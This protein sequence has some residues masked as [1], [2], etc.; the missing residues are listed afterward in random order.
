MEDKERSAEDVVAEMMNQPVAPAPA[1]DNTQTTAQSVETQTVET[2][3][4][5][6]Q[7]VAEA[8]TVAPVVESQPA[9]QEPQEPQVAQTTEAQPVEAQPTETQPVE[10][11]SETQ[12]VAAPTTPMPEPM[13]QPVS[14]PVM[15]EAAPEAAPQTESQP[16]AMPQSE[17]MAT[18]PQPEQMVPQPEQMMP[19]P[20]QM[21]PQPEQMAPQPEQ[22]VPQPDIFPDLND[23][24][25]EQ[26]STSIKAPSKKPII[27]ALIAALVVIVGIVVVSV[28]MMNSSNKTNTNSNAGN[29]ANNTPVI[30]PEEE[31]DEELTEEELAEIKA[32]QVAETKETVDQLKETVVGVNSDFQITDTTEESGYVA[33]KIDGAKVPVL[34][35]EAIGF[36]AKIEGD[37]SEAAINDATS[38]LEA[39]LDDLGFEEYNLVSNFEGDKYAFYNEEKEIICSPLTKG[40]NEI[41]ISCANTAWYSEDDVALA[42]ELVDALE[43]TGDTKIKYIGVRKAMIKDSEVVP[44][45]T[46]TASTSDAVVEFYRVNPTSPW[47]FFNGGQAM[48]SCSDY[49]TDDLKAAFHGTK[50]YNEVDGN[51]EEAVVE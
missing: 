28:I 15:P 23:I 6:P 16:V 7:P 47:I 13:A 43:K 4:A 25:L 35:D 38:Q 10:Q 42:N 19:Q 20:E 36:S 29:N 34:L 17:P 5:E 46:V 22:P 33:Y 40:T 39:K 48:H 45:Q 8:Q 21:V 9:P 2:P 14:E 32:E 41:S 26:P 37:N 24:N 11:P 12:P 18:M 27:L 51:M 50:C 49:N 44:Y 30:I 1:S 3:V 31:E